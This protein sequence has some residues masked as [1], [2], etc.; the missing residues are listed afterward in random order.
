MKRLLALFCSVM[1][2]MVSLT[3]CGTPKNANKT[4]RVWISSEP[5][6]LD[7]QVAQ[8]NDAATVISALYEGLCRLDANGNATPGAASSWQANSDSTEFTF[9]L[10]SDAVWNGSV[11]SLT[12]ENSKDTTATPLTAADFVFAWQR[13]LEPATASPSCTSMM[14]IQNAAQVHTG[15]V[16]AS[17]LG[18]TAKDSKTLVVRLRY[19]CPEFPQLTAQSVFMPC[20]EKFFTYASGR[21]GMERATILGNGP[22]TIPNYGWNHDQDLTLKRSSTYVGQTSALPAS[23]AFTIGDISASDSSSSTAASVAAESTD[24]A[25][26]STLTAVQAI[27]NKKLDVSP[28]DLSL[29]SAAKAASLSITS[30]QDTTCGLC[31]NTSSTF[32]SAALR[33]AFVQTLNRSNLMSLIPSGTQQ[34]EGILP[35]DTKFGGKAYR[36][37]ASGSMYLKHSTAA[38]ATGHKLLPSGKKITL[39]CTDQTK[40]LASEMLA[41][42]NQSFQTYFSLNAVSASE[43]LADVSSGSYDIAIYPYTPTSFDACTALTAFQSG[44]SGNFT[45]LKDTSFDALLQG[46]GLTASVLA[47]AE[48]RLCDTAV[49]YPLYYTRHAYA[50]QTSL[51]G[52][53]Y[54]PFGGGMDLRNA[55]KDD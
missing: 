29:E 40:A 41:S 46:S 10:R 19:S 30:F 25:D 22:F 13:A 48:Q 7:P 32:Q 55:G 51:S 38:A 39:L 11:G 54:R 18:A 4:I 8:G 14:C 52:V 44:Q 3:G 43:L 26:A 20:N 34:A 1:L 53:I 37:Q 12:G 36:A 17:E 9:H 21:Y 50:A 27:V 33:Q 35:P 15:T 24:S 2:L 31:F 6:T 16:A 28:L 45:K 49:F 47:Q 23:I 42:W 5:A